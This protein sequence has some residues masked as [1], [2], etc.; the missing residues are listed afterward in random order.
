MYAESRVFMSNFDVND[1]VIEGAWRRL[2]QSWS[3][4]GGTTDLEF[5]FFALKSFGRPKS[6]GSLLTCVVV[7]ASMKT[8]SRLGLPSEEGTGAALAAWDV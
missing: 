3:Y 7:S 8:P 5:A 6:I 2:V 4:S 1:G